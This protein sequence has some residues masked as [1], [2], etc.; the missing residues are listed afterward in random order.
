L[1]LK[2]FPIFNVL[3]IFGIP[4]SSQPDQKLKKWKFVIPVLLKR[5][6]LHTE[7]MN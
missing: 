2:F 4:I 1:F 6:P 3:F 5:N 7:K